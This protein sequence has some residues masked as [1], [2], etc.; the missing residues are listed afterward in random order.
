M[1]ATFRFRVPAPRL[2]AYAF[3]ITVFLILSSKLGVTVPTVVPDSPG[4]TDFAW[5]FPELLAQKRTFGYP[6]YLAIT[7][8][9]FGSD[10]WV[11]WGHAV[12]FAAA[13]IWFAECVSDQNRIRLAV[14]I[15]LLGSNIYWLHA[16]TIATDTVAASM[17]LMTVAWTVRLIKHRNGWTGSAVVLFAGIA[18]CVRPAMLAVIP[19]AVAIDFFLTV[20]GYRQADTPGGSRPKLILQSLLQ[21]SRLLLFLCLPV[22]LFCGLR[23]ATLGKFGIVS[24][25]GYNLIG[26]VGQFPLA[27]DVNLSSEDAAAVQRN[28]ARRKLEFP[29]NFGD[30]PMMNYTRLEANYD[31]AIWQWYAP[32]AVEVLGDDPTRVNSTLRAMGSEILRNSYRDYLVWLAKAFRQAVRRTLDDL[33]ES[34]MGLTAIILLTGAILIRGRW[35]SPNLIP[36][37]TVCVIYWGA[38]IGL[39]ILV[40]PPLSRMTDA[41]A[42]FFPATILACAVDIAWRNEPDAAACPPPPKVP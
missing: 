15:G 24:F 29:A 22:L 4:Y 21:S 9:V 6:L 27:D 5:S 30:L 28:A 7:N 35:P 20:R 23:F 11:G 12:I 8:A 42:V 33:A 26:L 34:P 40:C 37:A 18:W 13:A 2:V 1:T 19:A 39:T 32:A 16:Y 14:V 31:T 38:L 25:G 17:G 3:L 41:A 36:L 10:Q